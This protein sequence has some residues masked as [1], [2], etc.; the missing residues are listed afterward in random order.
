MNANVEASRSLMSCLSLICLF[1]P[2]LWLWARA[3]VDISRLRA[4]DQDVLP[5]FGPMFSLFSFVLFGCL[6]VCWVATTSTLRAGLRHR[7]EIT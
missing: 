2:L 5:E 1:L 6:A 3:V 7:K 4:E